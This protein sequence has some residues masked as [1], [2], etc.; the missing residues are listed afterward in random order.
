MTSGTN[1]NMPL[2]TVRGLKV[3]NLSMGLKTKFQS[4]VA[5]LL[6]KCGTSVE[7]LSI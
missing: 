5:L 3:M 6:R 2:T 7:T 4:P 1:L